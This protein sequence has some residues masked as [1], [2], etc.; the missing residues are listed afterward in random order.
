MK[1][2]L[3]P[4]LRRP[5][6]W[7][8]TALLLF[9]GQVLAQ[10]AELSLVSGLKPGSLLHLGVS[11]PDPA[12]DRCRILFSNAPPSSPWSINGVSMVVDRETFTIVP[13]VLPQNGGAPPQSSE[14]KWRHDERL[15]TNLPAGTERRY[16][17]VLWSSS[18][19][20]HLTV[21]NGIVSKT[22]PGGRPELRWAV[23]AG[24]NLLLQAIDI[25][26]GYFGQSLAI[27]YP[28]PFYQSVVLEN[29]QPEISPDGRLAIIGVWKDQ[30]FGKNAL[31]TYVFKNIRSSGPV[32]PPTGFWLPPPDDPAYEVTGTA[33]FRP[34]DSSTVW[35]VE[36]NGQPQSPI[37][38]MSKYDVS[39]SSPSSAVHVP[40]PQGSFGPA[41]NTEGWQFDPSGSRLLFLLA[42]ISNNLGKVHLGTY[43][44]GG[45]Q[46]GAVQ[47]TTSGALGHNE[48][49]L[50]LIPGSIPGS[51]YAFARYFAGT[52]STNSVQA[53]NLSTLAISAPAAVGTMRLKVAADGSYAIAAAP[54]GASATSV[55][56]IA[57][58]PPFSSPGGALSLSSPIAM[59]CG[60]NESF[61]PAANG[62]M[63]HA[64]SL[65]HV[66]CNHTVHRIGPASALNQEIDTIW[67]EPGNTFAFNMWGSDYPAALSVPERNV[68]YPLINQNR[69]QM[70]DVTTMT[71][72]SLNP[73]ALNQPATLE[74]QGR[75]LF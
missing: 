13:D 3:T 6:S 45:A 49:R 65:N 18:Q 7:L 17:A 20:G 21:S 56:V 8:A 48:E 4:P 10:N 54:A 67:D 16:Q 19:P 61:V 43:T 26:T 59:M 58:N 74:V 71:Y 66:N 53:I 46:A 33:H 62:S 73:T 27:P 30:Q 57:A 23:H 70:L 9:S 34:G 28:N 41:L 51:D 68:I 29:K 64:P 72:G 55:H 38:R 24:Q 63:V 40:L 44:L 14:V 22:Q 31:Y 69:L 35:V 11:A 39:G 25:D 42:S 1:L 15:P 12:I 32:N 47:L 5:V 2:D 60:P 50:V 52:A 36:W 75:F 37:Y